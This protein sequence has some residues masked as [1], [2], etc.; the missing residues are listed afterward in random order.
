M[1]LDLNLAIFAMQFS[2]WLWQMVMRWL[3]GSAVVMYGSPK[4]G[5]NFTFHL[6]VESCRERAQMKC[7]KLIR[8][9]GNRHMIN[10]GNSAKVFSLIMNTIKR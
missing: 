2:R 3:L 10:L 5:E 9:R 7:G 4:Y 1:E 6:I 8:L